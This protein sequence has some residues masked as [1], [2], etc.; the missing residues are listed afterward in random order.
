MG[1]G[2]GVG[3]RRD[4]SMPGATISEV[5]TV[6]EP[7]EHFAFAFGQGAEGGRW[8]GLTGRGEPGGELVEQPAGDAPK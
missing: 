1:D 8:L 3:G 2:A 6:W 7:G 5:F 4:V